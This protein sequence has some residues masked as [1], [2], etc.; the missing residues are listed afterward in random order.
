M[1]RITLRAKGYELWTVLQ[2]RLD[3][4]VGSPLSGTYASGKRQVIE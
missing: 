1:T 4:C 3:D 2:K